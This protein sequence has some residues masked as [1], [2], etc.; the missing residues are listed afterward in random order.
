MRR[1]YFTE[2]QLLCMPAGSWWCDVPRPEW[3]AAVSREVTR[4]RSSRFGEL[5]QLTRGADDVPRT[6][7]KPSPYGDD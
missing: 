2:R 1:A 3:I 7:P 5:D 6:K 4:M